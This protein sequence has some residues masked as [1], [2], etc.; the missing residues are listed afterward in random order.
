M[1]TAAVLKNTLDGTIKHQCGRMLTENN[2]W[3]INSLG[4]W[5][6]DVLANSWFVVVQWLSRVR[7]FLSQKRVGC[8]TPLSMRFPRQEHWSGLPFS[9]PGDLPNPGI[10]S[11]SP[12]LAGWFFTSEPPGRPHFWL[13][14][15]LKVI[16]TNT[17]SWHFKT[18][19]VIY[20]L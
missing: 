1:Q 7:L 20:H 10:K 3:L 15:D 6:S 5:S 17:Y 13:T 18:P 8:Q 9:P 11:A 19:S 14:I 16:D 2:F 12:E 4:S